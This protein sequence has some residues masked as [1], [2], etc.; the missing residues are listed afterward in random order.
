VRRAGG[1]RASYWSVEH[2]L[3]LLCGLAGGILVPFAG[4]WA[5]SRSQAWDFAHQCMSLQ[6][7]PEMRAQRTLADLGARPATPPSGGFYIGPPF[8]RYFVRERPLRA[9]LAC[10]LDVDPASGTVRV[11]AAWMPRKLQLSVGRT[12]WGLDP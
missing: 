10:T 7:Q 3:G 12:T 4:A 1:G 2:R 5:A 11:A 9:S 8:N 6:G